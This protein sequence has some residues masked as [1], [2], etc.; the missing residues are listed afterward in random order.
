[1]KQ[2]RGQSAFVNTARLCE[3]RQHRVRLVT[4]ADVY[5]DL[6]LVG[7]LRGLTQI[8][9][10][11]R[12]P[13]VHADKPFRQPWGWAT[14]RRSALIQV[15]P[16]APGLFCQGVQAAAAF[17]AIDICEVHNMKKMGT[18]LARMVAKRCPSRKPP[19]SETVIYPLVASCYAG[20]MDAKSIR[21]AN[22]GHLIAQHGS[23]AEFARKADISAKYVYQIM[24]GFRGP[25]DLGPRQVGDRM[26]RAI[27]R[28]LSLPHGW[29]DAPHRPGE[30]QADAA[31]SAGPDFRGKV[32]LISW[33]EAG[34]AGEAIDLLSPGAAEDWVD[35]TIQPRRHTFALRVQG[36]SM[37]PD[38]PAGII[39]VVEPEMAPESGDYVVA[40]TT[41]G[42]ATFKQFMLDAGQTF[43]KPLNPRY[44]IRSAEN[45]QIVGVVREAI[46]RFR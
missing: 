35:T 34:M 42:E 2:V 29:M 19:G 27:E 7:H 30:P 10:I 12:Q 24:T 44:P 25:K 6:A 3:Q 5:A 40:K 20:S 1:M 36:D 8:D 31:P 11:E 21:R 45:M 22:L 26:A 37:E 38:F 16:V 33:I 18:E 43:L 17:E 28:A 32:P 46:R 41:S 13:G 39:I 4:Q 23:A 9:R 15:F 14:E